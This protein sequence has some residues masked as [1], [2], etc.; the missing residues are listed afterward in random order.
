M[1][2]I[3]I[4]PVLGWSFVFLSPLI[5]A[6]AGALGYS[7]LTGKKLNDWLQKELVNEMRNLRK[8]SIPLEDYI[9]DIVADEMGREERLD[10]KK[11]D[12]VLTFRKDALGKFYVEVVGPRKTPSFELT[13]IGDEFARTIIQQFAHHRMARELDQRG[14]YI[15]GEEVNENGD[16]IL[17]TRKWS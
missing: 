2:L 8:V 6:A 3:V 11:D 15:V 16:I 12:I 4:A 17:H 14:V 1:P 10:F 9:K 5:M 13:A 7:T